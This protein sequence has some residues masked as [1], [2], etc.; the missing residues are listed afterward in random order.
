MNQ[1]KLDG[2]CPQIFA[3][4]GLK[5]LLVRVAD[6]L[7]GNIA[8][9][10]WAYG[11]NEPNNVFS[12]LVEIVLIFTFFICS[13]LAIHFCLSSTSYCSWYLRLGGSL[14]WKVATKISILE[15][16]DFGIF[17]ARDKPFC[18]FCSWLWPLFALFCCSVLLEKR[19][20]VGFLIQLPIEQPEVFCLWSQTVTVA[21]KL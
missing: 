19:P 6:V 18:Y 16:S 10:H 9:T 2:R 14:P 13:R 3:N 7:E 5:L 20:Y 11:I 17:C 4:S 1:N 21:I 15:V 8:H 12:N